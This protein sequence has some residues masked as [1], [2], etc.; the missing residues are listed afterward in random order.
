MLRGVSVGQ[1]AEQAPGSGMLPLRELLKPEERFVALLGS[2][3]KTALMRALARQMAGWGER[4]LLAAS[5]GSPLPGRNVFLTARGGRPPAY[6][7][8]TLARDAHPETGLAQ[9]LDPDEIPDVAGRFGAHRVFVELGASGG[10]PLPS[11]PFAPAPEWAGVVVAVLG[12]DAL[13]MPLDE[14]SADPLALGLSAGLSPGNAV[15]A[16]TL[17]AV[18]AALLAG[19]PPGARRVVFLNKACVHAL[20]GSALAAAPAGDVEFLAGSALR[21]WFLNRGGV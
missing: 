1:G 7:M 13:G 3:G 11:G 6:T 2:G 18:A 14:A 9:A 15:D 19:A 4:V 10:R 16:R 20:P 8:L 5:E 17:E 12:L 21:G